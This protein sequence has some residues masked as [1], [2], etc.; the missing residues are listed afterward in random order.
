LSKRF[1]CDCGKT[2][3]LFVAFQRN[4]PTRDPDDEPYINLAVEARADYLVI[5]DKDLLDLM[6][7]YAPEAK[8]FR[9]KF[10]FLRVIEP[11]EF[12]KTAREMKNE[13]DKK[14]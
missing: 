8:E 14:D 3:K 5:R 7:A 12:L 1:F 9:Q 11:P 10:R 4:F 13:G 2:R 6:T